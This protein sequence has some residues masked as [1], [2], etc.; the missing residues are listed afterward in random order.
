MQCV[1]LRA[2]G[3]DAI[4]HVGQI[5]LRIDFVEFCRLCRA[6]N[7]AERTRFSWKWP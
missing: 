6:P 2:A 7:Y 3:H 1:D 5:G 4:E